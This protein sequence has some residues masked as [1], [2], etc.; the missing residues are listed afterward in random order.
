MRIR[1]IDVLQLLNV[2]SDVY[3]SGVNYIDIIG[4]K[5]E[6]EDTLG[7]QFLRDYIDPE[8]VD[9]FKEI[10]EAEEKIETRNINLS[11]EDLNQ[12]I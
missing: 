2:L 8:Y 11:D 4:K 7:I 6:D 12:L 5:G 9:N 3:N 10:E 1:K